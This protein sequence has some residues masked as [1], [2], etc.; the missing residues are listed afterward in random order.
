MS[1]QFRLVFIFKL[2]IFLQISLESTFLVLLTSTKYCLHRQSKRQT[3]IPHQGHRVYTLLDF[4]ATPINWLH[5]FTSRAD[6]EILNQPNKNATLKGPELYIDLEIVPCSG[7]IFGRRAERANVWKS[8][9]LGP[10][11]YSLLHEKVADK[12][13]PIKFQEPIKIR[14]I[15]CIL[16][17][18]ARRLLQNSFVQMNGTENC[19][20]LCW[21]SQKLM[22]ELLKTS[23]EYERDLESYKTY[24]VLT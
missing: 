22:T 24:L 2:Q 7:D 20:Y 1:N 3:I 23:S 5:S 9:Q 6:I 10:T 18:P 14:T 16:S 12:R 8:T 13:S 19:F 15:A 17:G 4:T 11:K 21:S